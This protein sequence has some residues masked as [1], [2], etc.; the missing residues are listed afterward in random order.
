R[1]DP[2]ATPEER[3]RLLAA[4]RAIRTD[5]GVIIPK[6]MEIELLEAARSG[7]GD[8]KTLHDTMDETIAK[9]ILGQTM[10]T[11]NGSSKSQAEVH[12]EV[13]QDIVKADADL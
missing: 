4:L 2:G 7:T 3:Q 1:F 10:T 11:D 12:M 13:R 5:A 9:A 8:Y 6:G